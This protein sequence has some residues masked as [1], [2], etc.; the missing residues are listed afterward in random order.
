MAHTHSCT[1]RLLSQGHCFVDYSED[2]Q[3]ELEDFYDFG[4]P[5]DEDEEWEDVDEDDE[6]EED[7]V[8][9]PARVRQ[10]A[11]PSSAIV[12]ADA[13]ARVEGMQLQLVRGAK[14]AVVQVCCVEVCTCAIFL[15]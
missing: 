1:L 7:G 15:C 2:G 3:L 14:P 5:G 11:K 13:A 9:K 10:P 12:V 8:E 6:G 4:A